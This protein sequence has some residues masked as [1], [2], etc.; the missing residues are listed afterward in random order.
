MINEATANYLKASGTIC[1][2]LDEM[3]WSTTSTRA[4]PIAATMNPEIKVL[5][6]L[7]LT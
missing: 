6:F 5:L 2:K 4:T 7:I 1:V 3:I